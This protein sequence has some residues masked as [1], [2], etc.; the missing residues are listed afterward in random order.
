MLLR[1]ATAAM[2]ADGLVFYQPENGVW[3]TDAVP[4]EYL[5]LLP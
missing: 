5:T 3:L 1:V 4:T 2:V